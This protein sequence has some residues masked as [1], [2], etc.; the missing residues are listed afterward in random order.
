MKRRITRTIIERRE[1]IHLRI[2][3]SS[4]PTTALCPVCGDLRRM[5][6]PEAVGRL[7]G[8]GI[9]EVYRAFERG[10]LH[11]VE[12]PDGSIGVCENSLSDVVPVEKKESKKYPAR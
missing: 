6:T 2:E 4:H 12:W 7:R 5:T 10:D 11:G 8:N 1:T 3:A 9:R